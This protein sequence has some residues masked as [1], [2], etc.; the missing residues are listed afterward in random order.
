MNH[1]SKLLKKASLLTIIMFFHSALFLLLNSMGLNINSFSISDPYENTI[2]WTLVIIAVI[3][4]IITLG[5]LYI[6][7]K[8]VKESIN[9]EMKKE[10]FLNRIWEFIILTFVIAGVPSI[11]LGVF[12]PF[13][14]GVHLLCVSC[15]IIEIFRI[16]N[17]DT[18]DVI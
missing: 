15:L 5:I 2:A 11:W 4:M 13:T 12:W 1:Q 6:I 3:G 9:K 14:M 10:A 18:L 16:V 8:F 17:A 7:T